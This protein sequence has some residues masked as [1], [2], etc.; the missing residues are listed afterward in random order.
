MRKICE[1]NLQ[2]D[3]NGLKQQIIHDLSVIVCIICIDLLLGIEQISV[4]FTPM[5]V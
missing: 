2:I 5:K 1:Y 4:E 3:L